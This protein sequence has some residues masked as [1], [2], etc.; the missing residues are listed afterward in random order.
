MADKRTIYELYGLTQSPAKKKRLP[1]VASQGVAEVVSSQE[2]HSQD[3][4]ME[5]KEMEIAHDL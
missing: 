3:A 1:A 4:P 2:V 5:P